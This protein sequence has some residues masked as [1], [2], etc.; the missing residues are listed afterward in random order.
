MGQYGILRDKEDELTRELKRTNTPFWKLGEKYAI[1]IG[2]W[3]GRAPCG[4]VRDDKVKQR[5]SFP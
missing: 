3:G 2:Y 1:G 4:R 5:R